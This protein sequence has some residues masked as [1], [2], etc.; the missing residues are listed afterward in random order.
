MH[1]FFRTFFHVL[2]SLRRPRTSLWAESSLPM[3]V[4]PT[5]VDVAL[6]ISNG[7]YFSLMDLGRIDLMLRAGT[8]QQILRRGWRMVVAMETITFRKSLKLWQRY[9]IETRMVGMDKRAVY[10]EQRMVCHGEIYATATV[11]VRFVAKGQAVGLEEVLAEFGAPP[12]DLVLPAWIHQWRTDTAL[13]S[14]RRPAPHDWVRTD[15]GMSR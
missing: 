2:V 12:Q 15:A 6:H 14:T 10:F 3:R 8:W 1:L 9:S 7:V 5:D 11:A 13:P 4:W